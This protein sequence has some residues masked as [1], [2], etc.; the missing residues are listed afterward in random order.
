MALESIIV[1]FSSLSA[2]VIKAKTR[3]EDLVQNID[4]AETFL[5]LAG[6][7]IPADMQGESLVPLMKGNTPD[8]WRTHLYYHYYEY[9]GW[10]SVHRHE[11][12]SDKRYKL[13]R[14]YG[15]DVPNGEEWEFYDL[16]TDPSEMKSE[17]ANP[18]YASTIAKLKKESANL[19]K[20]Y[21]VK[22]IPQYDINPWKVL[23]KRDA[24]RKARMEADMKAQQ[25]AVN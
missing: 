18:E 8:D 19:R 25:K 4:F 16:K 9:P 10:H 15:K 13:M 14:F 7:P 12:V 24:V 1:S 23:R 20:K 2:G 11:G 22:D 17:Y 6:L 3:N 21:E 5:D